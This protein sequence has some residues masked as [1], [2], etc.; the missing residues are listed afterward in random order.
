VPHNSQLQ[1]AQKRGINIVAMAL[2]SDSPEKAVDL[3][4]CSSG[5]FIVVLEL[6]SVYGTNQTLFFL[7]ILLLHR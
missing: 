7:K 3:E 4:Q 5:N 2:S 1:V 6:L